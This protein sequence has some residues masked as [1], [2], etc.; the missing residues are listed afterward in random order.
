MESGEGVCGV[1]SS[2]CEVYVVRHAIVSKIVLSEIYK[3]MGCKSLDW[4]EVAHDTIY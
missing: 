2:V 1:Y 3:N 4:I